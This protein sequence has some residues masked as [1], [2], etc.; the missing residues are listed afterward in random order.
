MFNKTI[1]TMKSIKIFAVASAVALLSTTGFTS[2]NQKNAPDGPGTYNGETVK[3]QFTISIPEAGNADAAAAPGIYRMPAA[4]A[5]AQA[6]PVFIGMDSIKL[7]PFSVNTDTVQSGATRVGDI[8]SLTPIN[9]TGLGS[10]DNYKVYENVSIPLGTNHFLF[11]GHGTGPK[12]TQSSYTVAE[13]FEYG[14]LNANGL[15]SVSPATQPSGIS[16][17]PVTIYKGG[18]TEGAA[19]AT[20]LTTIANTT[21]DDGATPD[22]VWATYTTAAG[23]NDGIKQLYDNFIELEAGSALTVLKA[24]EDLYNSLE[25][26]QVSYKA[27]HGGTADALV[28]KIMFN[29]LGKANSEAAATIM[30]IDGDDA[31]SRTLAWKSTVAFRSYP[32]SI[33]LPD[34]AAAIDWKG[35]AFEAVDDLNYGSMGVSD[36]TKYVYPACLYYFANSAL[37]TA[38]YK[39]SEKY[40]TK[41]SWSA[42]LTDLYQANTYVETKTRSVAII[43]PIQYGVGMLLTTVKCVDEAPVDGKIPDQKENL[44]AFANFNLTAVLVG[45]QSAVNYA[46]TNESEGDYVVYDS[47][48]NSAY[49]LSTTAS[50]ANPTLVLETKKDQPIYMAVE[51]QNNGS[52]FYGINGNVIPAGTKFYVVA[53]LVPD[54][55]RSEVTGSRTKVFERDYKTLVNLTLKNLSKAYNVIPDLR[56]E[57]LE[58]GFSV[59]LNW[60]EGNTYDIT[61]N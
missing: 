30:D 38:N 21:I 7:L 8:I 15:G 31:G 10:V 43:N 46:F 9:T 45:G 12:A 26:Y 41:A 14:R 44:V 28:E 4:N 24:L 57:S 39:A 34:G 16:F 52:D 37:K 40:D 50:T 22:E 58:L 23:G 42:I 6:T 3:T 2:C 35:T 49:T 36:P 13:S 20:Y 18:N 25:L 56:T 54:G 5:Q 53:Q 48:L 1:K 32:R 55:S 59:D 51:F 29:I 19:I 60:Q 27:S 33:H 47:V 11:Y 17:S 61:I